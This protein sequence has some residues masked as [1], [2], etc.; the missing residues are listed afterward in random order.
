MTAMRNLIDRLELS[1]MSNPDFLKA[2][3]KITKY[4]QD[5][6]KKFQVMS[7][8]AKQEKLDVVSN[9]LRDAN[10]SLKDVLDW[11]DKEPV[12]EVDF[13]DRFK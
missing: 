10:K 9:G 12:G 1:E 4:V 11:F 8:Y 5:A 3:K 7:D 13:W 6:I 2:K